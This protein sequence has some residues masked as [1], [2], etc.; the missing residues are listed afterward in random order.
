M[1]DSYFDKQ[2]HQNK[3]RVEIARRWAEEP[4]PPS[5]DPP[6]IGLKRTDLYNI[7]IK[8]P[9]EHTLCGKRYNAEM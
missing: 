7:D 3:L 4:D 6:H 5:I 8:I 9:S 2:I 1:S